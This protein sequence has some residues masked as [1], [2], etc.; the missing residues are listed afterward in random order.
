MSVQEVLGTCHAQDA[1]FD[2]RV[3]YPNTFSNYSSD[4]ASVYSRH[5]QAKKG[6]M[7]NESEELNMLCSLHLFFLKLETWE[8]KQQLFTSVLLIMT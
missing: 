2:V 4:L 7:D 3:L 5:E 6:K 1:F 8:E